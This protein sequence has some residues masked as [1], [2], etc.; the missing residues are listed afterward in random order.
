VEHADDGLGD[1]GPVGEEG[2]G[3]H[4]DELCRNCWGGESGVPEWTME[5]DRPDCGRRRLRAA[6]AAAH[7]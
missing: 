6:R 1:I 2:G 3:I 5:G 4:G 7:V